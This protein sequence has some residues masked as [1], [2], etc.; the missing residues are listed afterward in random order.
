M[1]NLSQPAVKDE[2]AAHPVASDMRPTFR[3]IVESFRKGD[4][5][6]A[7]VPAVEPVT[8]ATQQQIK[9]YI[10][11]YGE[12]L[13]ELPEETWDGSVAQWMGAHWD[14]LVD[15]WTEESGESDLVLSARVFENPDGSYRIEVDSVHVP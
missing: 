6:L 10:A 4:F 11:D 3:E 5:G 13:A 7:R 14:V 15:L 9:D 8:P 1:S 2:D 12:T